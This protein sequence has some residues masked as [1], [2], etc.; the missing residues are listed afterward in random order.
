M[1]QDPAG[2]LVV[3]RSGVALRLRHLLR[4]AS[5]GLLHDVTCIDPGAARGFESGV[6][7]LLEGHFHR[8]ISEGA[9]IFFESLRSEGF[10]RKK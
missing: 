3:L 6:H 9:D 2:G 1:S 8:I 10:G 5:A 7:H 4:E